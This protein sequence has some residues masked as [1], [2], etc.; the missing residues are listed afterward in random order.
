VKNAAFLIFCLGIVILAATGFLLLE[1]DSRN[2]RLPA[3]TGRP[4]PD[5]MASELEKTRAALRRLQGS[6]PIPVQARRTEDAPEWFPL[7]A[8]EI[9]AA[10]PAPVPAVTPK[11]I[12]AAAPA[13][14]PAAMPRPVPAAAPAPIP[15]AMPRPIPFAASA[16]SGALF[17][18][19]K[20]D[21]P[22]LPDPALSFIFFSQGLRRAVI[23]GR[24]VREGELLAEGV[25]LVAIRDTSVVVQKGG[26]KQRIEIPAVFPKPSARMR[27][28]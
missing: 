7:S 14:V 10:A 4:A 2:A 9:A 23:D 12:P 3:R 16:P 20:N 26:R 6:I 13:P 18:A 28:P 24:F 15:A 27:K 22:A 19:T 21:P 11:P 1:P 8:A 25:R 17:D 5:D